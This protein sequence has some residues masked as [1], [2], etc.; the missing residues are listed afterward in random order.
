MKAIA[1]LFAVIFVFIFIIGSIVS[2]VHAESDEPQVGLKLGQWIR[3]MP[4]ISI[5]GDDNMKKF[6]EPLERELKDQ[7]QEQSGCYDN[8]AASGAVL[9]W[10]P[11]PSLHSP[12]SF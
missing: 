5:G 10:I 4:S 9:Y 8:R 2:S 6:L 11:V 3:Y 1:I 12:R 7:F